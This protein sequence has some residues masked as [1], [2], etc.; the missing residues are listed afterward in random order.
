MIVSNYLKTTPNNTMKVG[1][2]LQPL[3]F[4]SSPLHPDIATEFAR[5]GYAIEIDTTQLANPKS[6]SAQLVDIVLKNPGKYKTYIYAYR[7]LLYT[8]ANKSFLDS[9]LNN[10]WVLDFYKNPIYDSRTRKVFSPCIPDATYTLAGQKA[11]EQ[12]AKLPFKV[13]LIL[14]AGEDGFQSY[15]NDSRYW[16]QDPFICDTIM[17][18][19]LTTDIYLSKRKLRHKQKMKEACLAALGKSVPYIYYVSGNMRDTGVPTDMFWMHGFNFREL[20][21]LNQAPMAK[22]FPCWQMYFGADGTWIYDK[23]PDCLTILENAAQQG[24]SFSQY[25]MYPFVTGGWME[26]KISDPKTY[27]GALISL[28]TL[29]CT[30]ASAGYFVFP[31]GSYNEEI[32]II[33]EWVTQALVLSEV[34]AKFTWYDD[35]MLNSTLVIT[36]KIN[37]ITKNKL[38]YNHGQG[39]NV[40]VYIRKEKYKENYMI[41]AWS[42]VGVNYTL[43]IT[44]NGTEYTITATPEGNL[45]YVSMEASI[46]VL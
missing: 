33:P 7:S 38:S 11:A 22:S 28:F 6:Y 2:K 10:T 14:D 12:I 35:F 41:S 27:R 19:G 39:D 44:L 29:G 5:F 16:R 4:C 32:D 20:S 17:S 46:K 42:P 15:G 21:R 24:E 40:H 1:H 3:T 25:L 37:P 23:Q 26:G 31:Q 8:T 18:S 45:Y 30:G 13:D 9:L 34:Y 43:K 36:D